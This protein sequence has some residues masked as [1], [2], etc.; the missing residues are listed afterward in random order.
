MTID[1]EI[2]LVEYK[3]PGYFGLVLLGAA[4]AAMAFLDWA[5]S[6]LGT[7]VGTDMGAWV[8]FACGVTIAVLGVVGY[9]WNPFSDPEAL[10]A[11]IFGAAA[12]AYAIYKVVD[13]DAQAG[14]RDASPAV[15][16]WITAAAGG[17]AVLAGL[18]IFLE[19]PDLDALD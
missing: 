7:I 18:A 12:L 15:G 13:L 6:D 2:E 17:A 14:L 16:L 19:E 11:A 3:N 1:S 8:T 9:F 5:D 10:F 4:I